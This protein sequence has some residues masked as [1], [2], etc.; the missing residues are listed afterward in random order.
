MTANLPYYKNQKPFTSKGEELYTDNL[1]PPTIDSFFGSNAQALSKINKDDIEFKRASEIYESRYVLISDNMKMEDIVPGQIE[2]TYFLFAVQ[3]L[4]K[5]PGNINKLFEKNGT[6][7]RVNG[8]YEIIFYI[9][10]VQTIVIVDDYLPINKKTKELIG[11]KSKSTTNEIWVSLFEKAWAKINGG[12]GNIVGGTPME[13]LEFLTGFSS[14]SYD[15]TNKD[16]DDFNEYKIEIV[17]QLQ[18]CDIEN[19]IIACTTISNEDV[20]SKGLISGYTYNLLAIF[21]VQDSEGNNVYLF[22]LRNP[23]SLGEW[24]GDWSD[25]SN[26]WDSNTKNK[27]KFS[28]KQDGMFYMSDNDFFKYF[29]HVEICYLL[30]GANMSR[31]SLTDEEKNKNGIVFNLVTQGNGFLS[32]S[33]QRKSSILYPEVK[34]KMLPTHISVVKY[35]PNYTNR[36]KCFSDY[37]G[38]FESYVNCALNTPVKQGGY[39]IYIY[40]DLDHAEFTPDNTLDIN[41]ICTAK[42]EC[43]Q[44]SYDPRDK[45][46]PLLQNIILQAEFKE[47]NYDPEKADDFNVNSNQIRGNGIGHVIYYIS[48]PGNFLSYTGSTKKVVN[49]IFLNPYLD[50]KTTKFNHV[51]SSGKYLVLLGLLTHTSENYSFACFSKAYTTSK[52]MKEIYNSN[53][54]DLKL[55]IDPNNDI[56]N[57]EITKIQLQSLEQAKKQ[58]Y[59][60]IGNETQEPRN[61]EDLKKDK[62][63]GDYIKMLD[64]LDGDENNKDLKWVVIRGE[65]VIYVGQVNQEGKRTGKGLLINPNNVFAA[66][67]N[68]DLPNGKGYTYNGKKEK[69]YYAMYE[70]GIRVG[71]IVTAEEEA[72]IKK[73]EEEARRKLEEEQRKKEEEERKQREEEERKRKEEEARIQEELRKAEEARKAE[74]R[75]KEELRKAEEAKKAEEERLKEELRKAEEAKKA[76]EARIQEELRK[77]EEA[78]KAEEERLKEELRRAEEEAKKKAEEMKKKEEEERK[79]LQ[80]EAEELAKKLEEEKKKAEEEARKEKE[81]MEQELKALAEEEAKKKAEEIKKKE[82]EAKKKAEEARIAAEKALK[83]AEEKKKKLEEEAKKREEEA[84][85]KAEEEAKKAAEA[86]KKAQEEAKKKAEELKKQQEEAKRKAE[87][88]AK[89]AA[90]AIKKAQEEAKKKAEELKKQQEEAKKKAQKLKEEAEKKAVELKRQ[91]EEKK[92]EQEKKLQDQIQ[93]AKDKIKAAADERKIQLQKQKEEL[94]KRQ[95]YT[96]TN[97]YTGNRI[98]YTPDSYDINNSKRRQNVLVPYNQDMVHMCVQCCCNII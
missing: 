75:I 30:Y 2:D 92:K 12:Y 16:N 27:V 45:G 70:N 13:A 57:S 1:F 3:N 64:D 84:K 89:K 88:E 66:E 85:R 31:F 49:Y 93:K 95:R 72:E 62:E 71:D 41:I 14:L 44:M 36:L 7:I 38:N 6:F 90:D 52:T 19:A 97:D 91:Q 47:N 18:N 54:I 81:R 87:E 4:C 59:Y 96:P 98:N 77:A 60:D 35:D 11:A 74:E 78:R 76:E 94:Q 63:F 80:K 50:A 26:K 51:L 8:Y 73:A 68:N 86:I 15:M 40:R 21:Q 55:Y 67:F 43:K 65:Y 28:D 9:N 48:T 5:N 83:E 61:I 23:W 17:N 46:F 20:S 39:L 37:T 42:Y 24:N 29:K 58:T 82:E 33:V 34:G 79:R 32:V 69:Q 53:D 10:G 25:K 22:K 56:K